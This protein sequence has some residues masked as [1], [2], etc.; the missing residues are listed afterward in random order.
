MSASRRYGIVLVLVSLLAL[1]RYQLLRPAEKGAPVSTGKRPPIRDPYHPPLPPMQYDM[2]RAQAAVKKWPGSGKIH[3]TL[4]MAYYQKG[5]YAQAIPEME[6]ARQL[7]RGRTPAVVVWYLA[8]AYRAVG[9]P[10]LAMPLLQ[11]DPGVRTTPDR[12]A[13]FARARADMAIDRGDNATARAEFENSLKLD[14]QQFQAPYFLGCLSEYEGKYDDATIQLRR[15]SN[16]AKSAY[17][18]SLV[19]MTLG[20][21]AEEQFRPAEAE[22]ELKAA[23]AEDP[24]NVE[25]SERL[26]ALRQ[27]PAR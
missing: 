18:R 22:R 17:D 23:L 26:A 25:A 14:P 8:A 13:L 15:A 12:L 6:K 9:N 21:L 3:F 24:T 11:P 7:T 19:H 20:R 2:K 4:G 10:D 1:G 16:T 27:A 5:N